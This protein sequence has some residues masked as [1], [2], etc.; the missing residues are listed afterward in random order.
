MGIACIDDVINARWAQLS[1]TELI[2]DDAM[3]LSDRNI[4]AEDDQPDSRC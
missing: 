3:L 1:I 2:L 4:A